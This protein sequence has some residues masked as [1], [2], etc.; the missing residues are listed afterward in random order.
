MHFQPKNGIRLSNIL[1]FCS[2]LR[3]IWIFDVKKNQNK[4]IS[5]EMNGKKARTHSMLSFALARFGVEQ[6]LPESDLSY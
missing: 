2:L 1:M 3:R 5:E 4:K 6:L